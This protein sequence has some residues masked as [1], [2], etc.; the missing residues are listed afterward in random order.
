MSSDHDLQLKFALSL[1]LIFFFHTV[2]E[3]LENPTVTNL[4]RIG[5]FQKQGG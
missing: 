5:E 3:H 2:D 1:S 4:S